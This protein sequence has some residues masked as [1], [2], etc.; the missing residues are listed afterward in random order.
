MLDGV[1]LGLLHH[2]MG[3]TRMRGTPSCELIVD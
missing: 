2:V 3:A 1:A